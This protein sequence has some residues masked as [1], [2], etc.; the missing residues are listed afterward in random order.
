MEQITPEAISKHIKDRK[1]IG[2]SQHGFMK[3]K[4][5]LTNVTAFCDE[6]TSL[7]DKRRAVGTEALASALLLILFLLTTSQ[8]NWWS[9][10]KM[11]RLDTEVD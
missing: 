4:S 11:Y 3:M 5:H 6:M 9:T 7:V 1:V 8:T 10:E 2:S